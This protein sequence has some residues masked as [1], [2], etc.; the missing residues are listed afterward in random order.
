MEVFLSPKIPKKYNCNFCHY[1]TSNKKDYEKHFTTRKHIKLS[2]GSIMEDN[3]TSIFICECE[4]KFI[5]H[6]GL[7]KHKQKCDSLNISKTK[8]QLGDNDYEKEEKIIKKIG[9]EVF[10]DKN[11]I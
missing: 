8:C 10:I 4:K 3:K 2:N 11:I 1:H 7:W 6:G 9:K 5:T